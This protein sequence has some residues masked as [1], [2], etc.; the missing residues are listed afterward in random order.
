VAN[1]TP[2][3]TILIMAT[4]KKAFMLYADQKGVFDK[5]PN[6]K[7]GELIKHIFS[8]V[9]DE[10]PKTEDLIIQ[11]SFESIKQQLKRDLQKYYN[12]CN[13][14]KENGSKGGRPKNPDKPKKPTGLSGKK[15][16]I[17]NFE[18]ML[19]EFQK[20]RKSIKKPMTPLA[21]EKLKTKL[22]KLSSDEAVQIKIMEQS[23][24]SCWQD[25]Y[26]LKIDESTV[27]WDKLTVDQAR[28][29]LDDKKLSAKLE[30]KN[31]ELFFK[32]QQ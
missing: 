14:N 3:L 21:I 23:I 8:Y 10:D 22:E 11:I 2:L 31:P 13:R 26:A 19:G 12:I 5:L 28:E 9:N 1:F 20:M 25:V 18:Y 17:T 15:E 32:A 6:E 27:D 24:F 30:I 7:A 4:G 16:D 29:M